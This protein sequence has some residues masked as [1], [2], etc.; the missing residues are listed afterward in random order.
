MNAL[1]V[2]SALRLEDDRPW[3][4]AASPVQWTDAAGFLAEDSPPYWYVTRARGYSKTSDAAGM[5]LGLMLTAGPGWRGYWVAADAEQAAL[6]VDAMAGFVAR[7]PLLRGQVEV[8]ARRV[9]VTGSDARLDVLP[10]DAPGAWGLRPDLVVADERAM[11]RDT[12]SARRVWEAVSTAT[13]KRPG[14]RLLVV[15]TASSP[16][17]PAFADLE[18]ARASDLWAVSET[19]GPPPWAVSGVKQR[20]G[21]PYFPSVHYTSEYDAEIAVKVL[22]GKKDATIGL[23]GKS[24]IPKNFFQYLEKYLTGVKFVDATEEIDQI[25]VI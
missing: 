16:S 4:E 9:R 7:T 2:L 14:A 24:Y 17:H 10:A 12:E 11:W 18:H 6:G 3:G 25:K 19:P 15:T 23:V 22:K 8:Q 5:A 1:D 13:T 20:L 21:A